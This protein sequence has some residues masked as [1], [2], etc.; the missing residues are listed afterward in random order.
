MINT[1]S[2]I[3]DKGLIRLTDSDVNNY[4]GRWYMLRGVFTREVFTAQENNAAIPIAIISMI[5]MSVFAYIGIDANILAK[6]TAIILLACGGFAVIATLSCVSELARDS[7]AAPIVL[8]ILSILIILCGI[9][10]LNVS[11]PP[12]T[13]SLWFASIGF[14]CSVIG[15]LAASISMLTGYITTAKRIFTPEYVTIATIRHSYKTFVCNEIDNSRRY[16]FHETFLIPSNLKANIETI[17]KNDPTPHS[18]V[19]FGI[20]R[21]SRGLTAKRIVYMTKSDKTRY[22]V[23]TYIHDEPK[24]EQ[25]PTAATDSTDIRDRIDSK[26]MVKIMIQME[27]NNRNMDG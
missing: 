18:W 11:T 25:L 13:S 8:F 22:L 1:E 27:K 21:L 2:S 3:P 15:L 17:I 20:A 7:I 24:K 14:M 4:L 26:S 10:L 23:G 5:C 12:D 16:T 6:I 9:K 19:D